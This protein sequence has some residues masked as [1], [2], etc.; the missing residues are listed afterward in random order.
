M[1]RFDKPCQL[2]RGAV[3]YF[4][5]HMVLGDYL[6]QE[7][8]AELVWQGEGARMLG[9]SGVCRPDEFERVCRGLH[10]RTGERLMVRDKGAQRRV[11]FFGQI[12]PPKDVSLACLVA[13]DQRIAGWWDEAVRETLLEIEAT[14]ATRVRRG[15]VSHDRTTGCMVAAVVTHDTNRALDPQLHTHVCLL[16]LT[17]DREEK[18]W[19]GVQPSGLYRH[20]GYFR[21]VCY[22][23]LAQRL[24]SA[25]YQLD[26]VKGIGFNLT[27]FPEDLRS[28]FSKRRR[29]ILRQAAA[30]GATTQDE[31]QSIAS[32]S[33]AAKT[34]ATAKEL[35][36]GWIKEA[37]EALDAVRKVIATA[38]G[39][40]VRLP[41]A[42]PLEAV[43]SAEAHVFER[44]SVAD[45][46]VLLREALVAGRGDVSL[47][48]L[49]AAVVDRLASGFL[50]KRADSLVSRESLAAENE[51]VG[52]AANRRES[53]AVL[54]RPA[55]AAGLSLEQADAVAEVLE[56]RS[57]V[58]LL[59]G[60]AGTGK[61]TCLNA[62]VAGAA[63]QG[64]QVFCCAPSAAATDVLRRELGGAADTLQQL[65]VNRALQSSVRGRLL[66]VDEAG[67]VS[68]REMRDL[69]RL[70][71]A[72]GNR[73]LLVGDT[74]QHTAVEA[75][76]ALRCLH[77]YA[78]LPV[79]RL[80]EIRR[81][82]DP[83]FRQAVALLARKDAKGAM[84]QFARI[85]AVREVRSSREMLAQAAADYLET[86]RSGRSCLVISPVWSEIHA[87]NDEARRQLRAAG[88]LQKSERPAETVF[89]LK[90]TMEERRRPENYQRGDLLTFYHASGPFV[91]G[92]SVA[93]VRRE[94]D[95]VIVRRPAGDEVPVNVRQ[96]GGF[97]V[98][99]GRTIKV[100]VGERLLI[101][102]NHAPAQLKNGDLVEVSDLAG[103]GTFRLKDG[104]SIPPGFRHFSL[105]Y[106]TTS[107]GAQGRTVD[108]GILLMG[109]EGMAAGNL[110]Q[111][112]V[113]SSRF[114]DSQMIYTTDWA[115]AREAMR[116]PADRML[117]KEL[118]ADDASSSFRRFSLSRFFREGKGA[119]LLAV[120]RGA[121]QA[122]G[123]AAGTGQPGRN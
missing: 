99:L 79:A 72:N 10:P 66:I 112:Y 7:G 43:T 85:G 71:A 117:A 8:R 102:A 15:G 106:A 122:G 44:R 80:T 49:K 97:D 110:K 13:G 77:K 54:G 73:L 105:G 120:L 30:V 67:L 48:E 23:K 84:D 78:G 57:S 81:Q 109:E 29:E 65:L 12:S 41:V 21:E 95:K 114:R 22:N 11:C 61:T 32:N 24:R 16:N 63:K 2:V 104:R 56:S 107:H 18:R 115:G 101:R 123:P 100:A 70:A 94:G 64:N 39:R 42:T 3:A 52:W 68:V 55:A 119:R 51:F 19:K 5:E 9:L 121:P 37:G 35:R 111:A 27:G 93:V 60:D 87:F 108:R 59:Q 33:R 20:Q 98:G 40:P 69:C 96:T 90:W 53:E 38:A 58:I 76:D 113:S 4:R 91:Q 28:R 103:D 89:S 74:K 6:T 14:V 82:R 36:A 88:L 34:K 50:L 92:E 1:V 26:K 62:I 25:G 31:L 47:A 116:R 118:V 83:L 46:R 45:E 17:Y 75:G 86:I